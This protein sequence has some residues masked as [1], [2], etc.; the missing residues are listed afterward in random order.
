MREYYLRYEKN[1][2][3]FNSPYIMLSND[4]KTI[5]ASYPIFAFKVRS[6][7]LSLLGNSIYSVNIFS[8]ASKNLKAEIIKEDNDYSN[9][10]YFQNYIHVSNPL[11]INF[12][13]PEKKIEKE[14]NIELTPNFKLSG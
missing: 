10:F 5:Q 6:I 14:E 3:D 7:I 13:I 9:L 4:S 12:I 11:T 8:F 1:S 2:I